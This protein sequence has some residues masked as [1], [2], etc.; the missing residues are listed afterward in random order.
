MVTHRSVTQ[1]HVQGHDNH[2]GKV[3]QNSIV[4]SKSWSTTQSTDRSPCLQP[5]PDLLLSTIYSEPPRRYYILNYTDLFQSGRGRLRAANHLD[6]FLNLYFTVV[7]TEMTTLVFI[8]N[9]PVELA[10][11]LRFFWCFSAKFQQNWDVLSQYCKLPLRAELSHQTQRTGGAVPAFWDSPAP[12]PNTTM[13]TEESGG[14]TGAAQA[15]R[16]KH[17][18]LPMVF[19]AVTLVSGQDRWLLCKRLLSHPPP[20]LSPLLFPAD[21]VFSP[22]W[23]I[24]QDYLICLKPTALPGL[25]EATS[26]F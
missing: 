17:Q 23:R 7:C 22:V 19:W 12:K 1:C 15:P 11:Q 8:S 24:G 2:T 6:I 3:P 25:L 26:C 5:W 9:L 20:T 16:W 13:K 14:P 21:P 4:V 18:P 10:R